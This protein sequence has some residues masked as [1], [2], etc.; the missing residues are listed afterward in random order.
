MPRPYDDYDYVLDTL[1]SGQEAQFVELEQLLDGFPNGIDDFIG[2]R[3]IINAIDCGSRASIEWMLSRGVDLL[4]EDEEGYTVLHAAIDR[5]LSD[6]H[7][8]IESLL[9]HGASINAYG[10]ND[11]TPAHMAVARN[12]LETLRLLVQ[13]GAD[14]T[15][16]TRIDHYETPLQLAKR[17]KNAN[18]VQFLEHSA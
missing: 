12:D 14:L 16:R 10:I 18:A 1:R 3:W 8:I 6:K 17:L 9:K 13:F 5:S 7:E 2:R 11:W 4:F 15:I